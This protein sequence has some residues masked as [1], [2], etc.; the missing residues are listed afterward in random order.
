MSAEKA[1]FRKDVL[2]RIQALDAAYLAESDAGIL[3]QLCSLPEYA[4][5]GR[6]FAYWSMGRECDT[7]ALLERA[8]RRGMPAALPV[9]RGRGEMDF[10]LW[11]GEL[12]PGR[13]GIPEPQGGEIAFPGPG[14]LMAVPAV[15]C[16]A[17]GYRLG[18]GGGYYDR[19]LAAHPCFSV[20]L[21][22][23]RLLAEKIPRDWNDFPVS[24]V[25]TEE[26]VLR[27]A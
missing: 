11:T 9:C 27:R 13:L 15:C 7:R 21:C 24:A 26:R 5:A 16:D 19:Y 17:G 14:D 10:F 12:V 8:R 2:A 25:I 18:R 22:R 1:G 6:L 20:C 23:E 3:E 4:A